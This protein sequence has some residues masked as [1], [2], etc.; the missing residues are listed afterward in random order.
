MTLDPSAASSPADH[1]SG[2]LPRTTMV[3]LASAAAVIVVGGLRGAADIVGPAFLALMLTVA[4]H[5]VQ[6]YVRRRGWPA[7][8]AM[9]AGLATVYALLIGL[10]L[11]LVISIA[12]FA[13]LLPEYAAEAN[14]R[15]SQAT[16]QLGHFGVG[17]DQQQ[18]VAS[19]LDV[20]KLA[21]HLGSVLG[22]LAS[23]AAMFLFVIILLLFM[24][25]DASTLPGKL[26]ATYEQHGNF[27]DAL[28]S[29]A[30]GTRQYLVVSTIFGGIVAVIDTAALALLGVPAPVLWGLLAFIT[31]YI[32]NIGFIIGLIP[33]AALALLEGG[34]SLMLWV[35]V[36]YCGVNF[37]IQS[38]MQPKFIG[39][40]VGLSGTITMLSLTFWAFVLGPLGA[41]LAVPLTLLAKALFVEADERSR[42]LLPLLSGD[43]APD[44][45]PGAEPAEGGAVA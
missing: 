1:S 36:I 7:W 35:I 24:A 42:W 20:D 38:V 37:V 4:V 21:E 13:T 2:L 19:T 9:L 34:P 18:Q 45:Q 26:A 5:P 30:H 6:T 22:S 41:L 15:V 25:I 12:R 43:R 33:P 23:T 27:V 31:N 44:D 11:A 3:L 29:F 16:G 17:S 39:D 8:G 10:S 32:P 14:D 28:S 40:A